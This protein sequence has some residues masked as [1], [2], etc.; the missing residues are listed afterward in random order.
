MVNLLTTLSL[1]ARQYLARGSKL[2]EGGV[3]TEALTAF[4][5][6]VTSSPRMAEAYNAL[7]VAHHQVKNYQKAAESLQ[8]CAD[9]MAADGQEAPET[10]Q[11]RI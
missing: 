7:G 5:G 10:K 1:Q 9:L 3:V 11:N 8:A 2:L 4:Q 6:A